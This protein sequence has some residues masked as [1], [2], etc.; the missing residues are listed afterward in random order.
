MDVGPYTS[1]LVV[2]PAQRSIDGFTETGV[3]LAPPTTTLLFDPFNTIYR[4]KFTTGSQ[5]TRKIADKNGITVE[6]LLALLA[7]EHAFSSSG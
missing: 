6:P 5:V 3:V 1:S 2:E 4:P 7:D